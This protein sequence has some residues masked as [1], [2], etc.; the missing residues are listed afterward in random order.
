MEQQSVIFFSGSVSSRMWRPNAPHPEML[1]GM[2]VDEE[3]VTV[4]LLLSPAACWRGHTH[5]NT[6]VITYA[7]WRVTNSSK[8]SQE[9]D[10]LGV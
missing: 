9:T 1:G 2:E 6:L 7:S 8:L 10:L 3:G 5:K 4:L